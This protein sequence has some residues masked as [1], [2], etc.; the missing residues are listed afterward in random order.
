MMALEE[1]LRAAATSP[2]LLVSCDFDG[3]L[4]P[5]V[6][7]PSEARPDPVAMGA[8]AELAR[9]PH[10]HAAVISG[11]ALADLR[12]VVAAADR[13]Y[14][15]GSHGAEFDATFA[16]NMP[17]SLVQLLARVRSEVARV[18]ARVEGSLIED[19]PTAVAFHYRNATDVDAAGAAVEELL[20]GPAGWD[21]VRTRPG[22]RVLELSVA[23]GDKG[24]ALAAIRH[25][26]GAAT[27]VFMGDDVTDEDAFGVLGDV[28]MG[29]KI[30]LGV[31]RAAYRVESHTSVAEV[32]TRIVRLRREWLE[33][34]DLTPIE[35]H[36]M[37]SDQRTLAVLDP[38]GRI[39]WLCVPRVDSGAIFAELV[40]GPS[41][42]YFEVRPKEAMGQPVQAYEKDSFVVT[43]AW[44]GMTVT[45]YLD[46]S[47]GRPYQRAGRSD[48]MRV[49]EGTGRVL[50]RF[51]PRLDFGRTPTKLTVH[52][53]GVEIEGAV[54]PMVLHAPGLRWRVIAEGASQTAEAEVDLGLGP[55]VLELRCG[56]ASLRDAAIP[57]VERRAQTGRLWSA[58]AATLRVPTVRPEQVRRSALVLKSLVQGPTGAMVAAATTSLPETLGGTRNWDYRYCWPRDSSLSAA[59]LIKLGNTGVAMKLVDWLANVVNSL[60]SPERLRPIYDVTGRDLGP[61]AEIGELAGYG[62][63]RP[64]R[65]G[66]GAAGQVQLDVFG[67]I[68]DLVAM[69]VERGS[70]VTPESWRLVEA[71]VRAVAARWKEP[72]HGIWEVRGPKRHH[73][74]SKVMCWQA[75]D[76]AILVAEHLRGKPAPEWSALREEIAADIMANGW[77]EKRGAFTFVYGGSSLDAA[78]LYIG[79][80]GLLPP[81]D[82]RLRSTVERI[83]AEL[84]EGPVVYRY[85]E[86]D[87]LPGIEGGIQIC[88][89]WLVEVM[90]MI[91]MRD[92]ARALFEKA[93]DLAG[94]LGLM[95]EEYDPHL[96]ICLGNIPQAY[97]HLGLINAAV[98]L[99]SPS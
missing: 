61:E 84:L 37:L 82:P 90:A 74:H 50:V 43:T 71:A 4:A 8:L 95:T 81:E 6:G 54:D 63:S 87:G 88:T 67:P 70:P 65:I 98:R 97:S 52:E 68:V 11:R 99:A 40:G 69:L 44:G 72:D 62:A 19:K 21:G 77:N 59:A 5:I 75:V 26:V 96:K 79:L 80:T 34:R 29:V 31:S 3:T 22:L 48:L 41:R 64:V 58:W 94:P 93:A 53:D 15:V 1:K 56:T 36:A 24:K 86:D 30:G 9:M 33:G 10:T 51:A 18:A 28:D 35:R 89:F 47:A 38:R 49:V 20:A 45:D 12:S 14:M 55:L 83:R 91:G 92:E 60:E 78:V 57:E 16:E 76:R 39:T 32:L 7:H 42:G 46:C 25:R 85:R 2:I 17:A 27:V 73:V 13:L 23:P 66:N